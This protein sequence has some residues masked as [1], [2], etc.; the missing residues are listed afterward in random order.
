MDIKA[1]GWFKVT[2]MG[3]APAT[4]EGWLV[5]INAILVIAFA[6]QVIDLLTRTS[7]QFALY[8]LPL[9]LIVTFI[10]AKVC[11]SSIDKINN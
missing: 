7:Q 3:Y 5:L 8:F 1:Q 9:L 2:P 6:S 11:H 10:L 4:R